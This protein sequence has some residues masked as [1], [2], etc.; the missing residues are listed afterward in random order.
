LGSPDC[1]SNGRI[2]S[3]D[4]SGGAE[5]KNQNGKLDSCELRYGDLSLDGVI[6]GA[7]LGAMLALWNFVTPP[8]GDIT[9]DGVIN[10]ADLGLLLS[11]WG[12]VP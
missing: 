5:D 4:I 8:Y 7:D 6:N 3:C 2:D 12:P 1:D 9:G 11:R 10:G